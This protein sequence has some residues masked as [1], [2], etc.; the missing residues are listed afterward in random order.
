MYG[1]IPPITVDP[2]LIIS[3]KDIGFVRKE[4]GMAVAV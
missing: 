2:F 1:S 3:A 4:V